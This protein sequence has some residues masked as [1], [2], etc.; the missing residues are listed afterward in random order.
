LIEYQRA[1]K[2]N[3]QKIQQLQDELGKLKRISSPRA[4]STTAN[5]KFE[6]IIETRDME[7]AKYKAEIQ[8][9]K[10][11]VWQLQVK[12]KYQYN[13]EPCYNSTFT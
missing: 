7:I 6:E 12:V 13:I 8:K 10:H 11:E 1:D 9:L 5:L 2:E 4:R 3:K